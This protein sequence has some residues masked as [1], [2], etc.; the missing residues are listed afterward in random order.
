MPTQT[1]W[2]KYQTIPF[3]DTSTTTTP[4][5]ARIGKSTIFDLV[6]NAVTE[7]FDY[8]ED[9]NP[10]T[11][12]KNYKPSLSQELRTVAGDTAFDALFDMLYDLPT[13]DGA[14]RDVLLVFPRASASAYDSWKVPATITLTDF[15]TVDEKILFDINFN[16]TI[17]RGTTVITDGVPVFTPES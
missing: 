17:V 2:K 15:N 14:V 13:G 16:G 9:E 1:T 5:W 10:T 4:T 6:L 11:I 7:D 12:I 8:I 3:I